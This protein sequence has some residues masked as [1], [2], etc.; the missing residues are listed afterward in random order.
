MAACRRLLAAFSLIIVSTVVAPLWLLGQNFAAVDHIPAGGSGA[1]VRN[2][3]PVMKRPNS[4]AAGPGLKNLVTSSGIIFSGQVISIGRNAA[5]PGP[6]RG[7]T[8][9][10]FHVDHA[11]RGVSQGQRLTLHE[12]EGLWVTKQYY[13]GERLLL[14]LYSPSKLGLSSP[15]AGAMGSFRTDAEG[16]VLMDPQQ[17]SSFAADPQLGGKTIVPYSDFARAVRRASGEE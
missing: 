14:F 13:V 5:A 15:V 12:W 4:A 7:S 17:V 11:L 16:R 10:T 3:P 8:I 6:S 1:P 2:A 9:I